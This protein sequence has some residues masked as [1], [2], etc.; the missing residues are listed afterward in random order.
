[1]AAKF[2]ARGYKLSGSVETL[3]TSSE[4]RQVVLTDR[5]D[6]D[7]AAAVNSAIDKL[8]RNPKGF[9]L[10]VHSDCHLKDV[11]RSLDRLLAFDRII[12]TATEAHK[13]DTLALV[14]ADHSYGIRVEGQRPLKSSPFLSQVS[15]LDDHTGEDVP[16][17]ASGP[18]SERVKG[19]VPNTR[20]FEWILQGFGWTKKPA[21]SGE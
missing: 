16:V 11:K 3:K 12:E 17:L 14:T 6:F 20:V 21:G 9:F 8:S 7:L 10:V 4:L 5:D 13:R 18:G 19:F 15:L 1:M 2:R